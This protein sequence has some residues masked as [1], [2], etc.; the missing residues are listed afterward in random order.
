MITPLI[1]SLLAFFIVT[2]TAVVV[3][4]NKSKV[5]KIDKTFNVTKLK[6]EN[7]KYENEKKLQNLVNEVNLNNKRLENNQN[8]TK[9]QMEFAN[10]KTNKKV[11][12]LDNRFNSYKNITTANFIGMNNRVTSENEALQQKI[13][14]NKDEVKNNKRLIEAS[15]QNLE[16]QLQDQKQIHNQFVDVTYTDQ[17]N[18]FLKV[19]EAQNSNHIQL[20]DKLGTAIFNSNSLSNQAI[21]GL[22]TYITEKDSNVQNSLDNF[23]NHADF[24]TSNYTKPNDNNLFRDWFD[25]YYNVKSYQ[26]FQ[27]MDKLLTLADKDMN[28]MKTVESNIKILQSVNDTHGGLLDSSCNLYKNDLHSFIQTNYNFNMSNLENIQSNAA[29]IS[30]VNLR[31]TGLSNML[32]N[33]GIFDVTTNGDGIT[34]QKLSEDILENNRR[35]KLNSDLIAKKMLTSDFNYNLG[36]QMSNHYLNITSNLDSNLLAERLNETDLNVNDLNVNEL[37]AGVIDATTLNVNGSDITSTIRSGENYLSNLDH[38]FGLGNVTGINTVGTHGKYSKISADN[39]YF[40]TPLLSFKLVDEKLHNDARSLNLYV[41]SNDDASDRVDLK[42]GADLSLSRRNHINNNTKKVGGRIFVDSFDDIVLNQYISDDMPFKSNT[43]DTETKLY[44]SQ[45][46]DAGKEITLGSRFAAIETSIA[47]INTANE[48][49]GITKSQLYKIANGVD[50][51]TVVDYTDQAGRYSDVLRDSFRI[52]N[53]YTG[54]PNEKCTMNDGNPSTNKRCQTIDTRLSVLESVQTNTVEQNVDTLLK[55]YSGDFGN[56]NKELNILN[57]TVSIPNLS[58]NSA[59]ITGKVN[60]GEDASIELS[61][62]EDL[63]FKKPDDSAIGYKLTPF[64]DFFVEKGASNYV[65]S[66]Q[67]TDD[68]I[69][70]TFGDLSTES[71]AFPTPASLSVEAGDIKNVVKLSGNQKSHVIPAITLGEND[72][73]AYQ[74]NIHNN[75]NGG[76]LPEDNTIVVPKKYVHSVV[77]GTDGALTFNSVNPENKSIESKTISSGIRTKGEILDKLSDDDNTNKVPNFNNGIKFGT[78]GCLKM[79]TNDTL[80]VCDT[81]CT[82]CVD[83]WDKRQAPEP[84]FP[85]S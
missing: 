43:K 78:N 21:S 47:T 41:N 33:I 51:S 19:N 31:I 15:K 84:T 37:N 79:T 16:Q 4:K 49:N 14:K 22:H 60:V 81:N 46:D 85:S 1:F 18:S 40:P 83:V 58:V 71:V 55:N 25:D 64:K 24:V 9:Q 50:N 23:F 5:N 44:K 32:S 36:M 30:N 65:T 13:K 53:L 29:T 8:V 68:G 38:V 7:D 27:T 80:Q 48:N 26:N 20:L 70:F 2:T 66:V 52:D 63:R 3:I 54:I 75:N 42:S 39:A 72:Y 57:H 62:I 34:L 67:G 10:T 82:N 11:Q 28:T 59:T 61:Q 77:D 73:D 17:M 12:N 6:L 69:S 45:V 76:T 56:I 74:F 35:V